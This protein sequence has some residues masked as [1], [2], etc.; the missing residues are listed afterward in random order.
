MVSELGLT[1]LTRLRFN[2]RPFC[3]QVNLGLVV[4]THA[5]VIMQYNLVAVKGPS[6]TDAWPQQILGEPLG[7]LSTEGLTA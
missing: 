2:S 6:I 5:R 7:G 4:Y 1:R 3:F